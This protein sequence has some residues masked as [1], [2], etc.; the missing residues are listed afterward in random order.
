MKTLSGIA[1]ALIF[2]GCATNDPVLSLLPLQAPTS[3]LLQAI[4]IVDDEVTWI[5]GHDASFIRSTNSGKDWELFQHPTGDTLQFRDLHG[6]DR[7]RVLLLSSGQGALSRIF[8]FSDD[9]LW[10]ENFVM[11]DTLGFLDC[12][13][14]WNDKKGIAYGDSFDGYPYIL[15]TTDGGR[16][17]HRVPKQSLPKAGPGEGGFASSGTC[18]TTGK[19]GKAWIATG[20]ENNCRVL[21]TSDYGKTWEVVESPLVKGEFAGNTSISMHGKLGFLTG[22]DLIKPHDYTDNHAFTKDGGHTWHLA[23]TSSTSG[24]FYGGSIVKFKNHYFSFACG[25]NGLDYT[26]DMGDQ[27]NTLDTLNYWSVSFYENVGYAVGKAGT[28]LKI[29]I[30]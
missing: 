12:L 8:T 23:N 6:F 24:P 11:E 16:S 5:S 7:H 15:L 18:V 21:L 3:S 26:R 10:Q 30:N 17:W 29:T 28:I 19:N 9:S 4:S 22:G 25:P 20:A 2:F 14:F 1:I 13:D 27:W